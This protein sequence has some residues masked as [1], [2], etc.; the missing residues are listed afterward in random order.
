MRGLFSPIA[1]AI[2]TDS[3]AAS[4]GRQRTTMLGLFHQRLLGAGVLALLGGQAEEF[5]FG[6]RIRAARESQARLFRRR[7]R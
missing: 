4:S 7:H 6:E 1:A 3:R 2:A 5:D